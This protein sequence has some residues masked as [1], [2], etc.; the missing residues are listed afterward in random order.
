MLNWFITLI[1]SLLAIMTCFIRVRNINNDNKENSFSD[2]QKLY[3]SSIEDS[4]RFW[5]FHSKRLLT[6]YKEFTIVS[7]GS[8]QDGNVEWFK[9]GLLNVA[10]NCIDRH[11]L[12]R[13][14]DIAI[15]WEGDESATNRYITFKQLLEESSQVAN[16]L[17]S[18]GITTGDS[19]TI[20]MPMV[21]E[22]AM[23]MLACARIGAIHNVVFGG[24]SMDALSER[25]ID[26]KSKLLI[27][28][29]QGIR[30]GKMI[31]FKQIADEALIKAPHVTK[32]LVYERMKM[33][34]NVDKNQQDSSIPPSPSS[35]PLNSS[36]SSFNS[37]ISHPFE[38]IKGRDELWSQV[39]PKQSKECKA[40]PLASE[41]PLFMLYT[42]GSTGKP[43]GLLHT[44]GGYLAF[45]SMTMERVFQI[46]KGDI[47]GCLADVGWITGHSYIVYGPLSHGITT[48]MFESTPTWPNPS[49]YWDVIDR[50]GITHLYTA[51]TVIR[52]LRRFGDEPL[53]GYSL[54]TLK[55]LGSV[56]E[57][58]NPDAWIWYSEAVGKNAR[59][60]VDT[61]W[62]TETGG[63]II[64][65]LAGII[66][67]KPGSATLPF[68]GID[69]L[70]LDQH[71]GK[72]LDG[73]NVEGVLVIKR[74]W[75]GIART[76]FGD[77][78]K[79][80]KT[81]FKDYPGYYCTGDRA[82]RDDD[83]Y[84][85]IR[86]RMDDVINVSGHRLST[87]ELEAILG[88][89]SLCNE[90]AVLGRFDHITGQSICAF[91]IV[92]HPIAINEIEKREKL[93]SE[94]RGL[95]KKSI[96]AF[97]VP[98]HVILCNDLPKTRSGKIMRRI[99]RKIL[100]NERDIS[101]LGDLS[102]LSD[103]NV[104]DEIIKLVDAIKD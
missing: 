59:P 42:S 40:I 86:G 76:I 51:P 34:D 38:M 77:H 60:I 65:P 21:P 16:Y 92:K 33:T 27:T 61:Y 18:Q 96:G 85:W 104:I 6:W 52:S 23:A 71:T 80:M 94:L 3:R 64:A 49:R 62:Q 30:A 57:P 22:A 102:T 93:I 10:Y 15:I 43:K 41:H 24:F 89:H 48:V 98:K 31:P 28:A 8:L 63:H 26:S 84:Y 66:E 68:Y 100:E 101:R 90:A 20:Y 12:S 5:S 17:K 54:K 50:L 78:E 14:N 74:P 13:P 9:D 32:V 58:I 45:V 73:P 79:Y 44:S 37:S 29:N 36:S 103:P 91:C 35:N 1:I 11:A 69:P 47:F 4:D 2:Y 88:K 83:G 97:A 72:I 53:N 75:P 46:A 67:T 82:F 99:I 87:G 25:L 55:V 81:Y 70:I 19:V 56:G 95:V 39:I 7:S